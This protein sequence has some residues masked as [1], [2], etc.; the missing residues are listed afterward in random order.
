VVQNSIAAAIHN[1]PG[2]WPWAAFG[3]AGASIASRRL[4]IQASTGTASEVSNATR[5]PACNAAVNDST[6]ISAT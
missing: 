3:G 2:R 6:P 1:T 4:L 5:Q